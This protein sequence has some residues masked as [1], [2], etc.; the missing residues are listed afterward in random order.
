MHS[1]ASPMKTLAILILFLMAGCT[2]PQ[3][4]DLLLGD[5]KNLPP[6]KIEAALPNREPSVYY[7][8]AIR[9]FDQGEKDDAVFWFY[10]GQ[11]RSR[12][13]LKANPDLNPGDDPAAYSALNA[14]IGPT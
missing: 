2:K 3:R 7:G 1:A 9:L 14:T 5:L 11:L 8:Y 10:V 4:G 13:Y 6:A 12:F